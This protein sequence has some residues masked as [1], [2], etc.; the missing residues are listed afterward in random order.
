MKN[1]HLHGM[2][3]ILLLVCLAFLVLFPSSLLFDMLVVWYDGIYGYF[4]SVAGYRVYAV[5]D[6]FVKIYLVSLSIFTG[7]LIMRRYQLSVFMVNVFI[8][9]NVVARV[10][11]MVL[12]TLLSMRSEVKQVL[13]T[14]ALIHLAIALIIGVALYCYFELSVRARNTLTVSLSRRYR[15][16]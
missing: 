2:N 11:M 6:T 12:P 3:G 7:W 4:E 8:I 13:E 10:V 14:D 15:F 5:V 9:S 1:R 16:H